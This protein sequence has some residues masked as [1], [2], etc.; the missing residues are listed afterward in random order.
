MKKKSL[1]CKLFLLFGSALLVF[2]VIIVT[3]IFFTQSALFHNRLKRKI[4]FLAQEKAGLSLTID[5]LEGSPFT[6]M[7]VSGRINEAYQREGIRCES[8]RMEIIPSHLLWGRVFIPFLSLSNFRISV[9][10]TKEGLIDIPPFWPLSQENSRKQ[11]KY[12]FS[13]TV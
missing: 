5:L 1:M 6:K 13:F 3:L 9:I 10:R 2:G 11:S 12:P 8:F 7:T 4:T